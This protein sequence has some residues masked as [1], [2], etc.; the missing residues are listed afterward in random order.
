MPFDRMLT[1]RGSRVARGDVLLLPPRMRTKMY[2]RIYVCVSES[3][4]VECTGVLETL[5]GPHGTGS[6]ASRNNYSQSILENFSANE[7]FFLQTSTMFILQSCIF[8][9]WIDT[10]GE[11]FSRIIVSRLVLMN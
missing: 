1:R 11:E 5:Q 10:F 6:N 8:G 3:K 9:C 2:V 4:L 7:Y